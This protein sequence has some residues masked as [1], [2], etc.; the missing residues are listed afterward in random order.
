M[1]SRNP[2]VNMRFAS[3]IVMLV[4]LMGLIA[5]TI[6]TYTLAHTRSINRQY[7]Q[8]L[9]HEARG[10]LIIAAAA[11]HLSNASRIA[12]TVL[13]EPDESRML[14]QLVKLKSMEQQYNTEMHNFKQLLPT[15][16]VEVDSM[17]SQS[18]R[19]FDM[20]SR[21]IESAARW[22]GDR[23]LQI[24][25]TEFEPAL[26]ALRSDMDALR[27]RSVQQFQTA[28]SD[29]TAQTKKTITV[30]AF[31]IVGALILVIALSIH[32]AI[33]QMSRPLAELTRSME[34]MSERQYGDAMVLTT[35]RDEVGKMANAL[36]VFRQSMQREDRL[37]VEVAASAEAH[38]LS[39]QLMDLISAIPGAVFQMQM[40]H[41]G[42]RRIQFVSEK[43]A[44]L[45]GCPLGELQTI[46]G[47]PGG[48][49]LHASPDA[50]QDAQ[51]AFV[52][53]ARTLK[54]L[55]FDI[56][57]TQNGKKRW[58]K[59]LATARRTEEGGTMFNGVWLDVSEQKEQAAI[60]AQAKDVAEQAAADKARFLA[61]M[62]HEIR[63][64]L[65][66]M[67]GM[68]QLALRHEQSAAQQNRMDK[69]LRAGRHLLTIVND[70]LDLS[71]IEAGKMDIEVQDFSLLEWIQ[72]IRELVW[73]EA[74]SKNLELTWRIASDV[75]GWVRGSRHRMGQVLINYLNNAIKFTSAGGITIA[76]DAAD[77][78]EH[79]LLLRCEV[80]DSG[81]GISRQDQARLF[82]AFEQADISITRRF[83]GTGLGL[84]IS[85]QLAQLMGG[86]A[87]VHSESGQGS[88]FWFTARVLRAITVEPENTTPPAK[89]G[90][91]ALRGQRVLLVDDNEINR[92]VAH[93]MLQMG[94]VLVDEAPDGAQALAIL[95]QA[96]A[97]T[98]A[99][100]L[101]DMQM[102]E[103]DGMTATRLLREDARFS[104]LPVIALTANASKGD[105][106]R[107]RAAGMDD[108][109]AKPLL[110][111]NLWR[112]VLRWA[113]PHAPNGAASGDTSDAVHAQGADVMTAGSGTTAT[114]A[115]IDTAALDDLCE[116]LGPQRARL[117]MRDFLKD[118]ATR[119]ARMQAQAD[120]WD[121]NDWSDLIKEAHEL[122]GNAGSFG[123]ARLGNTA[124]FLHSAAASGNVAAVR[125]A[126]AHLAQCAAA[127]LGGLQALV[128]H[129][130]PLE[131]QEG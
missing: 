101:M 128:D 36:Q 55:D 99:L 91:Q 64:P 93:G 25:D 68:T 79:S 88:T 89:R 126:M 80:Q 124:H 30:T 18:L 17:T 10:A 14:A 70:V 31:A 20:A 8:L 37:A 98:Y 120:R 49:F 83:G 58:L 65:N 97:D 54:P 73:H 110:E 76:I 63:T 3:K 111:D 24:I 71:K 15:M 41:N 78:D 42:W 67:L 29:L 56:A 100:V 47:P 1:N 34:R 28:S 131:Q 123:L 108:H 33:T 95:R 52:H 75:P 6:T 74:D 103:M 53:S 60:L 92:A 90:A 87:G 102:P 105:V 40:T 48:E 61:T 4:G 59:T 26:G 69:A 125:G 117:L 127:D 44:H 27:D 7:S 13:T 94:G 51:A 130:R 113:R 9:A 22:R 57:I 119:L 35:R 114:V 16:A 12:Y 104:T 72:E 43:A 23:A 38:R 32:V 5:L 86:A 112:C 84:T 66:A 2:F 19:V 109:L 77:V 50:M 45:H 62:S 107:T 81:I 115:E 21:I 39:Q 106:E 121:L 96:P 85:R 82:A 11:Q 129:P 122:S 116:S 46:E 118:T